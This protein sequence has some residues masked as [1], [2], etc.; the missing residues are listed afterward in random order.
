MKRT[1]ALTML[2]VLGA[3]VLVIWIARNTYWDE[4]SVPQPLRGDAA[5]NPFYA[6][7]HLARLLGASAER[8]KDVRSLSQDAQVLVLANWNWS[9]IPGRRA[10]IEHW[11]EQGGRLVLDAGVVESDTRM[12][13]WS[14]LSRV[15]VLAGGKPVGSADAE[16]SDEVES[17]CGPV[18]VKHDVQGVSGSRDE[19][20][21]CTLL[22][23][24]AL[25][26]DREPLWSLA[27]GEGLQA[28]RVRVG[29]GS[30]TWLNAT[31]FLYRDLISAD[32]GLL[33][34][35]A[36]QL[37]AGEKVLFMSE[38]DQ[39]SL[40][41]LIW[42]HGAPVVILLLICLAAALWRNGVRFGPPVPAT[43]AVRRSLAE[44]IRGTSEFTRRF[45]GG[46]ALHT[47]AVRSLETAASRRI[48]R[49][50]SMNQEQR[51]DALAGLTGFD[52][53][54]LAETINYSGPRSQHELKK[55]LEL[56]EHARRQ[57]DTSRHRSMT[58][59]GERVHGS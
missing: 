54:R 48:A 33:F 46:K 23:L 35:A 51:F 39:L 42:K 45:G 9:L 12:R 44:Q 34:V 27:D 4:V 31:P 7:E 30:V 24:R 25:L 57:L 59:A 47:A 41:A 52:A 26:S 40:L 5:T 29:R 36:T 43:Q 55:A 11:V 14:G 28:V 8:P 56:L 2:A 58:E 21:V 10:A 22:A 37:R 32:H 49:Y 50:H 1:H 38:E 18:A 16:S 13:Q 53:E 6:A 15:R 3:I 20:D 17:G 19:Y